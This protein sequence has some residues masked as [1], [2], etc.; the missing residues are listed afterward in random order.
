MLKEQIA[1]Q[2]Y[3]N[4][5]SAGCWDMRMT[6]GDKVHWLAIAERILN[7][8]KAE[9][10]KLTVIDDEEIKAT[11]WGWL[12]NYDYEV[13][14]LLQAQLNHTKEQLGILE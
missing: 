3:E 11:G 1:K 5:F 14:E 9:V 4:E 8:F 10:D 2:L 6:V 13:K 12:A 7:L